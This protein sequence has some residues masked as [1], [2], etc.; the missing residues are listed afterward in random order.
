[1]LFQRVADFAFGRWGVPALIAAGVAVVFGWWQIDKR[2]YGAERAARA[3]ATIERANN[4]AVA[5][6][7]RARAGVRSGGVHGQRDPYTVD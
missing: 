2:S 3:V 6:V 7:N 5:D 1:M 4:A